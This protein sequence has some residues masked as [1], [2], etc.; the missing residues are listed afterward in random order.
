[1][2][3]TPQQLSA[4]VENYLDMSQTQDIE[5]VR[6]GQVVASLVRAQRPKAELLRKLAGSLKGAEPFDTRS[7]R[8]LNR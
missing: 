7:E 3:I 1:M 4:D 6:G 5:V 2:A 8:I